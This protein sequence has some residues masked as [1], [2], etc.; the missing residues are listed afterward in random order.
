M[1]TKLPIIISVIAIMLLLLAVLNDDTP[2]PEAKKPVYYKQPINQWVVINIIK[3]KIDSMSFYTLRNV[4]TEGKT[5]RV[6]QMHDSTNV[7][8]VGDTIQF[9]RK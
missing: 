2:E 9:I 7:F 3:D 1:K 5:S 4:P 6:I 8:Y